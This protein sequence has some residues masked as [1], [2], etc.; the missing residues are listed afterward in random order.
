MHLEEVEQIVEVHARGLV[1]ALPNEVGQL[2]SVL[3][4][5]GHANRPRP[6]EVKV[7]KL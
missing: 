5:G 2:V 1:E 3:A 6:V 7:A 4:H